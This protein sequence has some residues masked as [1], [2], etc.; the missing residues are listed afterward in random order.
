MRPGPGCTSRSPGRW[1]RKPM[2][3]RLSWRATSAFRSSSRGP[4][5]RLRRIAPP[6]RRPPRRTIT[7]R[8]SPIY[9]ARCPCCQRALSPNAPRPSWSWASRSCSA[10]TWPEHAYPF[11]PRSRQRGRRATSSP[12]PVPHSASPAA[13]SA[14]AGRSAPTT[15]RAWNCCVGAWRRW[16]TTSLALLYRSSS[17]SPTCWSS[18]TR[19][20]RWRD[21][22]AVPSSSGGSSDPLR[23]FDH[24]EDFFGFLDTAEECGREDL[25]FRVVQMSAFGYYVLGRIPDCDRAVEQMGEIAQRLGSPRF[26]WEVDL[27]RGMRLLDRGDRE[28]GVALVQRAGAVVRRLRP[29]I[30]IAIAT[31]GL[32]TTEWFFDGEVAM[33]RSVYE[34][35]ERVLPRG[36]I[37][38]FVAFA[39]AMEGDL[40]TARRRMRAL[41]TDD[42]ESLRRPDGHMP[43]ALWALALT[44][45]LVGDREAGARLRP[46]F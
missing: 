46:L 30:H 1:R 23:F 22:P 13:T 15:P 45:T 37:S 40:E 8:P 17:A 32:L 28:G 43:T 38:A 26:T 5:R 11:A 12:S 29:D 4:S 25:L 3:S 42:L 34:A 31:L 14:S 44:A 19:T 39:A 10:P 21:L 9:E 2:R 7:S 41:L 18:A 33:S 35:T 36:L 6:P 16:A 27:N 24:F 20:R